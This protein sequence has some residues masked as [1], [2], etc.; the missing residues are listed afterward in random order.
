MKKILKTSWGS[1]TDAK[2]ATR[3]K[4]RAGVK[5]AVWKK[6]FNEFWF[7]QFFLPSFVCVFAC[8]CY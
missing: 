3:F 6:A 2:Y 1:T 8:V 4:L 5:L 7:I